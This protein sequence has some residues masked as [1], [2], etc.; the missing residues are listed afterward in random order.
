[1]FKSIRNLVT[2]LLMVFLINY[3]LVFAAEEYDH[4]ELYDSSVTNS[5]GEMNLLQN[6]ASS[7]FSIPTTSYNPYLAELSITISELAYNN[8][9]TDPTNNKLNNYLRLHGF[10]HVLSYGYDRDYGILD[11]FE[12]YVAYSIGTNKI[13]IENNEIYLIIVA[14]RGSRGVEWISNLDYFNISTGSEYPGFSLAKKNLLKDLTAYRENLISEGLQLNNENTKF[15]ITGH[16]RGAAVGNLLAHDLNNSYQEWVT[17]SNVY[18]Y[19]FATPN[20][21]R[22]SSFSDTNIRNIVNLEDYVPC[23]PSDLVLGFRKFGY[24]M[25]FLVLSDSELSS[26]IRMRFEKYAGREYYSGNLLDDKTDA[27]DIK[28]Y[29][30][31]ILCYNERYYPY[32]NPKII[33]PINRAVID[34]GQEVYFTWSGI[35]FENTIVVISI[36]DKGEVSTFDKPERNFSFW[37]T[38]P[39]SYKWKI[40][41]TWNRNGDNVSL[42]SEEGTFQVVAPSSPTPE[43]NY[44]NWKQTDPRWG[45]MLLGNSSSSMRI[46]GCLVTSIATAMRDMGYTENDFNPKVLLEKLNSLSGFTGDGSYY[47]VTLARAI[48]GA[49]SIS[50]TNNDEAGMRSSITNKSRLVICTYKTG[51]QHWVFVREILSDGTLVVSDPL[52][53]SYTYNISDVKKYAVI[54]YSGSTNESSNPANET[55]ISSLPESASYNVNSPITLSWSNTGSRYHLAIINPAGSTEDIYTHNTTYVVTPNHGGTWKWK[56]RL[57]SDTSVAGPWSEERFLT[58]IDN[59]SPAAPSETYSVQYFNNAEASG[60][61]ASSESGLTS[62]YKNWGSENSPGGC[63]NNLFSAVFT[64]NINFDKG[65]Y[66][67]DY[68]VDDSVKLTLTRD[69]FYDAVCDNNGMKDNPQ[70]G[71]RWYYV[72]TAG[73]YNVRVEYVK[74]HRGTGVIEVKWRAVTPPMMTVTFDSRGGTTAPSIQVI[75]NSQVS[76]PTNPVKPGYSFGGW[77]THPDYAHQWLFSDHV[78]D[79]TTLYAKWN[80]IFEVSSGVLN[81]YYGS[82]T[83]VS[84]PSDMGITSIGKYAFWYNDQITCVLIPDGVTSIDDFAFEACVNLTTIS[85]PDSVKSIG[86]AT[87]KNCSKLRITKLP[88]NLEKINTQGFFLCKELVSVVL[89]ETLTDISLQAF[90]GCSNLT[91]IYIPDST[92]N[93]AGNAFNGCQK[94][95]LY[96][97]IGSYAETYS[98]VISKP[99][100]ANVTTE[101]VNTSNSS[102]KFKINGIN[103]TKVNVAYATYDENNKMLSLNFMTSE[104]IDVE[105]LLTFDNNDRKIAKVSLIILKDNGSFSPVSKAFTLHK[106]SLMKTGNNTLTWPVVTSP[107]GGVVEYLVETIDSSTPLN[108]GWITSTSWSPYSMTSGDF[109]WHVKSRDALTGVESSWLD[110]WQYQGK[111]EYPA[112]QTVEL[113]SPNTNSQFRGSTPSLTWLPVSSPSGGAIEYYVETYDCPTPQNSGWISAT[114]WS[115]TATDT[116]TYSWRV[117]CID[118]KTNKESDWS[119]GWNYQIQPDYNPPLATSHLSPAT[120]TRHKDVAPRLTWNPVSCPSGGTIEYYVEVYDCPIPQNSGWISST[121]WTP[122][123][124]VVGFYNW[125]VKSIDRTTGKESAWSSPWRFEYAI[126]VDSYDEHLQIK[127]AMFGP[128]DSHGTN[129]DQA[130]RA[131]ELIQNDSISITASDSFFFPAGDPG[132]SFTKRMTIIYSNRWNEEYEI[133]VDEGQTVNVNRDSRT[134]RF[135]RDCDD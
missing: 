105:K 17:Q 127:R 60:S 7:I 36:V 20:V 37:P 81:K 49:A 15:W 125:R 84:I 45:N 28:L 99:F 44:L 12:D 76:Q 96:G 131:R 4:N 109:N 31:Y 135:L 129:T 33:S 21:T 123:L 122:Y 22:A 89:P 63:T 119:N 111:Q 38:E 91:S 1:M 115:P 94:L 130:G 64:G 134:G 34:F 41:T 55:P 48:S 90:G 57:E 5:S 42:S 8:S 117:K 24:T 100:A 43:P 75:Y 47:W 80:D 69:G 83:V 93:I 88:N 56:V 103:E 58:I 3:C 78:I 27:H 77:Y 14:I 107:S 121:S 126:H 53:S 2:F 9:D 118:R 40:I 124:N 73:N 86:V 110:V 102:W 11:T 108:S 16:S 106:G 82:D 66:R 67:F 116:G 97:N 46:Y 113:F 54:H 128:Y 51:Y 114:S 25:D 85:I 6:E 68:T 52:H 10:D 13:L 95:T 71:G 79:N 133:V 87:F 30:A 23:V 35:D 26:S 18:A 101:L 112:P 39:G 72:E 92:T 19:L 104:M 74:C 65:W 59:S 62:I 120:N 29:K 70:S 32:I 50:V 61:V 98:T 132:P